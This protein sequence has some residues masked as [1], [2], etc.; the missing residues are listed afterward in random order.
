MSAVHVETRF[1]PRLNGFHFK[2]DFNVSVGDIAWDRDRCATVT[3]IV[4]TGGLAALAWPAQVTHLCGGMCWAALDRYFC[5]TPGGIPA[6]TSPP[7]NGTP[8][9]RELFDRQLDSLTANGSLAAKCWDWMFRPNEGHTLDRASVGHLTQAEEWPRVKDL[10]DRGFPAS[11]CL[12][13]VQE[14]ELTGIFKAFGDIWKNHQVLAWGYH[15]D[16]STQ[17]G[18]LPIYDPNYPDDDNVTL[19]FT[20]GQSQSRLSATH[21]SGQ[22]EDA[23]RGFFEWAYDRTMT[24]PPEQAWLRRRRDPALDWMLL[25]GTHM[26]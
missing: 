13:R 7:A 8:L 9:F 3:A 15:F 5:N 4:L 12:V 19:G 24:V 25:G 20:L 21:S 23:F 22:K 26:L 1:R 11:L 6:D 17:R 18:T 2:N 16:A 10:L 14:N